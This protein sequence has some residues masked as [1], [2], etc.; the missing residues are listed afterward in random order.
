PAALVDRVE[1]YYRAQGLW[2]DATSPQPRFTALLEL[3]MASVEPSLA[4]PKR[5]HDRVGLGAVKE[6][7]RRT[8]TA[9]VPQDGFG[10]PDDQAARR[11][12]VAGSGEEITHGSVVIA[13]IT[14]C[15]NTSNPSVMLA[16]GLLARNAVA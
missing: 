7:F 15:T 4:G 2:R 8:L 14:S 1:R 6:G 13:A 12:A 5:P 10:V 16:A 11:A 9:P 3:D